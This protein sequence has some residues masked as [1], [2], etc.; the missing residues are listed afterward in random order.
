ME[1]QSQGSQRET[2]SQKLKKEIETTTKK[3]IQKKEYE[4]P[5]KAK[6]FETFNL[7][8]IFH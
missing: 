2:E 1:S 5:I 6:S 7:F 8:L 3:E 4:A